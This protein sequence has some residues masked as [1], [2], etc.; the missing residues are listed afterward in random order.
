MANPW[1][2]PIS[3]W[4]A[5]AIGAAIPG[6]RAL[7]D[8]AVRVVDDAGNPVANGFRWLLEEDNSYGAVPGR[9]T[10]NAAQGAVPGNPS[11]TLGVNIHR[12]HAP[13][14]CAGDTAPGNEAADST[15]VATPGAD[16]VTIGA[17]SSDGTLCPGYT[18]SKKYIVSVLPWHT[19]PA[20][21]SPN[22]QTGY[23][24]SGRNVAV[25]QTEVRVVVHVHPMPTAQITVLVFH[26]NQPLNAAYDQPE[27]VG[28]GG[29]GLL[30][31][32]PIG[33][34]MQDAWANPLGSTYVYKCPIPDPATGLNRPGGVDSSGNCTGVPLLQEQQPVFAYDEDNL[35]VVDFLG[36][37]TLTTCPGPT[38]GANPL[39]GYTPY[40]R[41]NCVDPYTLTPLAAGEAV[42]RFLPANKYTIEPIPPGSDPDWILT[43]TLEGTRG[44]DAWVRASE[45]RYNITLGQLNWLTFFGFVK[46]MNNLASVPNP[47]GAALGSITGQVVYVHDAHPPLSPGLTPGLPVLNA[48]VGVNNLNGNDEQIYTA[49]ANPAT[50]EFS[51][52]GVVPGTYQL[53]FWDLQIQAIIDYRTVTVAPGQTLALGPVS[54]Y[55]WFGTYI[56]SVFSDANSNGRR[57]PAEVGIP[58]V[59]V[60]IHF[61]DGSLYGTTTSDNDGQFSFPQ[62]FA[63]WRYTIADVDLLRFKP[64]GMTAYVDNGGPLPVGDFGEMGMN[65]QRQP[66]GTPGGPFGRTQTGLVVTQAQQ[67]FQ[68]MTNRIDWGKTAWPAGQNGGIHGFVNYAATRTEEDPS[69][70]AADSW[71]PSVPRVAVRLHG[72]Q[73]FCAD[74]ACAACTA[75]APAPATPL[76]GCWAIA[77]ASPFPL[78]TTTD[79][80][81]DNQPT[82]CVGSQ[83]QV[84][85]GT[86]LWPNPEV[87]NG[88]AIPSCAETFYNWDQIRP[89]VMDGTYWF[90]TLPSGAPIPAGNYIVEVVAPRGYEVLKWG[91]RNIE[92]GDP[93]IPFLTQ[94]PPC[95]GPLYAVPKYHT[96]YPDQQVPTDIPGGFDAGGNWTGPQAAGCEQKLIALNPGANPEVDFNL[97]TQVPKAARIWGTV[98]NDLTLEFNP[99]SPNASGNFGVPWLP[100][101]IKDWTGTE[102]ARFYTDQWGHFDGLVPA[103]YDIAPPIPLGLVLSMYTIAPND[104]GPVDPA[105]GRACSP[106]NPPTC[107]IDP[108]FDPEYSQEVIRENWQFYSGTTT[109]IDTIVLP[110]GAFVGN[111][112][113]LNC[114]F[115]NNTPE[116]QSV[117]T[118]IIPPGGT[119]VRITAAG[120]AAANVTVPNP[121]FD[122]ADVNS[123]ATVTWNHGF[124]PS[125]TV[126]VG[127]APVALAAGTSWGAKTL[128]VHVPG[129][130]SGQLV[131]TR[132]D[133]GIATT[134][135]VTLHTQPT[136]PS[137][138]RSVSPPPAGCDGL[139][140]AAI[141]PVLDAAP[142]GAILVLAP[143]TYQENVNFWKP[144]TLQGLGAGVTVLDGTAA[145]ANL[146]LKQAQFA[147]AQAL[148]ASG[149]IGLVP[150]QASNFTLEQGAGIL[151]AGCGN[152][153]TCGPPGVNSSFFTNGRSARIDGLSITGATEA[154]GGILVNGFVK[155]LTI[156]NNEI[157]L[158][159]GSVG[160]GIRAGEAALVGAGNPTGSS[161]NP[162]LIIDRNR[163]A[164]NGSLFSGGGGVALYGG[165]DNYRVTNNMICGNFSA[166][167]GGG[168]GH[169]GLVTDAAGTGWGGMITDNQ[170]VS[171]ESFDEGGGIHIGGENAAGAAAVGLGAGSVLVQRNLIQGNKAGD[172]GGG[173]RT[174]RF[175]GMDVAGNRLN[176]AAW[177]KIDI[178]DNLIVN[179][180]SADHG[181]GISFDDTVMARVLG[182]TVAHNDST[183]TGSDAFGGA[184]TEN[185]P[186]GQV[187]PPGEVAG[188][189]TT[190]IPQVAGIS[191]IAHTTPLFAILAGPGSYCATHPYS[192]AS[193][194]NPASWY[195][196]EFSNPL[197]VD[198]IVWNNRSFFW[199]ATAN[200]GLGALQPSPGRP[201]WDMAVYGTSVS[202]TLSPSFSIMTLPAATDAF[203][204]NATDRVGTDPLFVAPY[205]NVYQATSAGAALGNFVVATFTPNGI[206]G[207]YHVQAGSAAVG[208]GSIPAATPTDYDKQN[209]V[210]HPPGRP[211]TGGSDIGA[212]QVQP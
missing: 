144:V 207:N 49:P 204:P 173:I 69:T 51:I 206:Q 146:A 36:D 29:F 79:S 4:M 198:D 145:L 115:T 44:N 43:G 46:P 45:P 191:S 180:S 129:G 98:W 2:R 165:S 174:R 188:G 164:Q 11:Y 179:N 205:F 211:G 178:L 52:T 15:I 197:L 28:L 155:N 57:E 87:V 27:E 193:P 50:G 74:P 107:V 3:W 14:V 7:A 138:L 128:M 130:V 18:S 132:G 170:V 114:D 212:D 39:G 153:P 91:D 123:P 186:L 32:D 135:G 100:V 171:N 127:G 175:N 143:G 208:W 176:P 55:G 68:D 149:A 95:V 203:T 56:G 71:E 47:G 58:N 53:A 122:P 77:D 89:G 131:V 61:T 22:S 140:C 187:C 112:V 92:F 177:Y 121:N 102:V 6:P 160:G 111:R 124:G 195:C 64:T 106:L 196:A 189:L 66:A 99:A 5:L 62:Y 70:S 94:P 183:A 142:V 73:Q 117:S 181:G 167:Y 60:N 48:F 154:G 125:G 162:N 209:R 25:G 141:Q 113:P 200:S 190:S 10:P 104:P 199:N 84:S 20:G 31:S 82:G 12:S 108:W 54:I 133:N 192:P 33:K 75:G 202:R 119:D 172:D 169:F 59:P 97:F 76:N 166:Q 34:T 26:D 9:P 152:T 86:L 67:L 65:P 194:A 156:S 116:I 17:V 30:F 201:I 151:V 137:L 72:A 163:I 150:N 158:N 148:I 134:V 109:F 23:G 35:P 210:V 83:G 126:T 63:W 1:R 182:N 13:V 159:Q 168:I 118:V 161:F 21:V 101:A 16:V 147:Q 81:D 110:V 90:K 184:C 42:I 103:N 19:S 120:D 80:W 85:Q 40:Q 105:T 38:P 8:I 185:T 96:L 93:K 41:A 78:T 136:N 88:F 37:S 24:M 139:A 157:F